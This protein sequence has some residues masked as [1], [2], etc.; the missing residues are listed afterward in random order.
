MGIL[1]SKND[2]GSATQSL[3][4]FESLDDSFMEKNLF[5]DLSKT[6]QKVGAWKRP[7]VPVG[8]HEP[9]S[10]TYKPVKRL[11]HYILAALCL[12]LSGFAVARLKPWTYFDS[13]EIV[14]AYFEVRA[15]DTNG[16]PIAGAVVKNGGK[17]VGTTDSFGEWRRYMR[18]PLGSTV[19]VTIAKKTPHQL[20][21]A[22]KNFAV[23]PAKPEKSEIE[24]RGSVQLQVADVND[25]NAKIA[26]SVTPNDMMKGSPAS[27]TE[28]KE[29][30]SK[31][32]T[33][34]TALDRGA[35]AELDAAKPRASQDEPK[36]VTA[37]AST[38]AL[39]PF[40]SNHET[41]A[42]EAS[43]SLSAPLHREILPALKQRATELGLRVDPN[44]AWKV[45][46]TSLLDKPARVSKEGGGL[47]MVT[48]FDGENGGN[49]REFLRNYQPDAGVTAKG[50]LFILAQHVE[51][52]VAVRKAGDRWVAT[53][54]SNA[55][56]LWKL[57]AG[58]SLSGVGT[59]FIL[60]AE[61]Y[62]DGKTSGYYLQPAAQVPCV[63]DVNGCELK[64]RSFAEIAPV[65]SWSRLRLKAP[66]LGKE[67][68]K[69]FVSGYEAKLVGDKV[70][71]YWGQDKS[72]A[73]V[74]VVQSGRVV[75]RGQIIGDAAHPANLP[76]ANLSRR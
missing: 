14:F 39:P 4:P 46:L 24:L 62:S 23:P 25:S 54:P 38:D 72:R 74:T 49:V 67:P 19:P 3:D 36:K 40:V 18:V 58:R 1:R 66:S 31:D 68:V 29:T 41:I 34:M 20:L 70:Y 52:N 22:T 55:S 9:S 6:A 35:Q 8:G 27:K 64:T 48:S 57:G 71:E 28:S 60:S 76:I 7:T 21:F 16:R 47:I 5:A 2:S 45:R 53:L 42:F 26:V 73:N 65:P 43:G 61:E 59:S 56:D 15:L 37:N 32:S 12:G 63:K 33:A 44:A 30:T 50:I 10:A 11:R 13:Q 17:R 75:F 69:I 51:K